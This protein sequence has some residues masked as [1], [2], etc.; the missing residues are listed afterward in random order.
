MAT[1]TIN[2]FLMHKSGNA[3]T[4][5]CDIKDYPDLIGV[6]EA[7]ETT[8]L[9]NKARTFIEGLQ[10]SE[11]LSFTANY[12]SAEFDTLAGLK[13]VEQ[14]LAVWFD[15]VTAETPAGSVGKFEFKGYVSVSIVGKG[16]NEVREMTITV[17]PTTEIEKA[18]A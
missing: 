10:S 3:Y 5:L 16:V 14:E 15:D 6:P 9:S 4:K 8:T 17:T 1:S 13:G 12:D 2:T 11:Q 7:L 18:S